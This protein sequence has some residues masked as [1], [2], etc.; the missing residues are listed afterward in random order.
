MRIIFCWLLLGFS[1]TGL[2]AADTFRVATY[3]V[4]NY[5]DAPS[6]TRRAK[7]EKQPESF[8]GRNHNT[9][10]MAA[11]GAAIHAFFLFPF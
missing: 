1:A 11:L 2:V 9:T 4:E 6:G 5:L 7:P 10:V 8:I 3:N